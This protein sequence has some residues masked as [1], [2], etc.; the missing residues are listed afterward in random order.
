MGTGGQT[1]RRCHGRS[2]VASCV[3]VSARISV[4]QNQCLLREAPGSKGNPI[5][6]QS[7]SW[8]KKLPETE[9]ETVAAKLR[10]KSLRT[11]PDMTR[12]APS[13]QQIRSLSLR[14]LA[15]SRSRS[16][17]HSFSL[18]LSVSLAFSLSFSLFLALF[19][20]LALVLAL[21]LSLAL[22]HSLGSSFSLSLS[23]SL[24]LSL[25]QSPYQGGSTSCESQQSFTH[26]S[27]DPTGWSTRVSGP[28]HFEGG[29]ME[30][31]PHEAL[32]L[33]AWRK[34]DF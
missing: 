7:S 5:N 27:G 21:S 33:I 32:N 14:S 24:S 10:I 30:F 2:G 26:G 34:V 23:C 16:L 6:A 9:V 3:Q 1:E 28:P 22:A 31:K 11:C 25:H 20:S 18:F 13:L 19:L 4:C 15:L 8:R 17:S 12:K 29:V